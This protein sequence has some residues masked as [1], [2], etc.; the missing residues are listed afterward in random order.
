[1][2]GRYSLDVEGL[3]YAGGEWDNSKYDSFAADKDNIIPICDDEYFEDDIVGL[4]VEFVKTVYGE[5][6]LNENLK[7]MLMR[8]AQRSAEGCDSE[9][10]S[11][12]LLF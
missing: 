9:L 11:E 12:W 4:F 10:F 2:F 8:W 1:M 7:F 5:D 6:T 3:A